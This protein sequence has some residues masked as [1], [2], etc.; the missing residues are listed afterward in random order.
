MVGPTF[1]VTIPTMTVSI[2]A[3]GFF[4]LSGASLSI[5][6][7][8]VY[9]GFAGVCEQYNFTG[10]VVGV[11][12]ATARMKTV[13]STISGPRAP[14]QNGTWQGGGVRNP[15]ICRSRSI[16]MLICQREELGS[17]SV[18]DLLPVTGPAASF[19]LPAM[20]SVRMPLRI[21]GYIISK[22]SS[23]MKP[24]PASSRKL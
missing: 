1:N 22:G 2:K 3:N 14:L 12:T 6:G 20:D 4:F 10:W 23:L 11:D 21:L 9:G 7:N 18:G 13:F 5:Y 8:T 17:G 16:W 24:P 15:Q 19:W